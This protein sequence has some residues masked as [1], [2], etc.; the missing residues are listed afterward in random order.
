MKSKILELVKKQESEILEFKPSL[1]QIKDIIETISAFSNTRDGSI[2]IGIDDKRNIIGVDVGKKTIESLANEIKQDTDPQIYPS[3]SVEDIGGKNI[4]VVEVKESKSKPVF[5]FDRVYKRVGKS[6]HKV[7]SD[8]IRKMALEGK[9]IY[10]DEQI[11]EDASLEDIDEEKVRWFLRK[12]K[13]ERNFDVEPETPVREALERLKL[14]KDGKLTNA[15]VLLFCEKPQNFFLQAETRC[16]RFKGTEPLEF[17]DMKVFGGN[18]IDQREDAVEFVKEH[19]RLHAKIVGTERVETWEYPIEAIREAITN[20]VCH[21]DYEISSNVQV[22]IFDDR[23]EVWGCGS[24]L[25]PLT[26]EDLRK[27]HRSILRNPLIGKCFFLI[28]FVEEWGTGTNRMIEWC[29]KHGL[30]EPLFEELSGSLVVIF[31]KYKISE[32]IIKELNERQRIIVKYLREQG[33]INR[34]GCMKLLNTSKDTVFRE[35]LTLQKK[36]ILM[37]CGSGKNVY[38]TLK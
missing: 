7:S 36:N 17:I 30:P 1:S 15:A 9:K 11:C 25:E 20:A 24:L 26:L 22:R 16:A 21:R 6:N 29:L 33:K 23:I 14:I 38:Y 32:E 28:K 31:R 27:K 34:S 2:I 3:I 10:W 35:L 12:A 18:I 5:A 13:Y 19:I 37:R 4:I 8:E